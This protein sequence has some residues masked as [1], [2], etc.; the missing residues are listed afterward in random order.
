M[1]PQG[2]KTWSAFWILAGYAVWAVHSLAAPG[3]DYA[4]EAPTPVLRVGISESIAGEVNSNDLRAAM[5]AWA[6]ELARQTGV[7]IEPA[8]C[9]TA[10]LVQK[11]RDHQLDAFSANFLEFERV[12]S[13]ADRELIV[14]ASE[15]P[16]GQEYVLLVHQAS[17]LQSLADLR[18]K[19]LLLY[20]NT[21]TCLDQAWLDTLLSSA[22]LGVADTFMGRQ[23]R[24]A[25]LSRVVL[26][27]FFRQ[28]DACIVTRRGYG[29][30]C[31]LNPQLA[32]Q[33]RI[34]AVSPKLFPT[35]MAF[36]K[37]VPPETKRRFL[38][39]VLNLH[40]SAAGRQAL[41]LFGSTRLVEIDV[42]MLRESFELLHAYRRIKVKAP[43]VG[44]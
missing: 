13:Y 44:Q 14:D 17:G 2:S 22:H 36:Q 21:R 26:P 30:L 27:V 6:E 15:L 18:G 19:S 40:K 11:I 10:Q 31:E 24:N 25:K 42:S 29:T 1:K 41:M 38:A 23:E 20:Q 34:L 3:A 16:D 32:R 43:S 28:A 39:A 8:L 5:K 35:F 12:A 4:V 9:T 7:R 33:L 37:G